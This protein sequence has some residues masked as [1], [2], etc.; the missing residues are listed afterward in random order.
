MRLNGII[1]PMPAVEVALRHDA[2]ILL[3]SRELKSVSKTPGL[4]FAT[5]G[6]SG[7]LYLASW[8][9]ADDDGST[10]SLQGMTSPTG[11]EE[12]PLQR[13]CMGFSEY[14]KAHTRPIFFCVGF[15]YEPI[16]IRL[17]MRLQLRV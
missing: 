8:A 7:N 11:K 5:G 1:E 14:E 12:K 9:G 10:L 17:S 2:G 16:W 4:N 6:S 13:A 15:S 3:S